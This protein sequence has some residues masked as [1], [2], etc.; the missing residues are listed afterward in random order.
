MADRR[1]VK[2]IVAIAAVILVGAAVL[3]AVTL[4]GGNRTDL[5]KI[6]VRAKPVA[7]V[8]FKD[9]QLGRTPLV[10]QIPR[11]TRELPIE[12]TFTVHKLNG[13]NGA[14]KEEV[15]KQTKTIVPDAPQSVDFDIKA[16]TKQP[17][18]P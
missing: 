11:G 16:A 5:V 3:V 10:I 17:E 15:W 12:A 18:S 1:K 8:R 6:E 4:S 9:K 2:L 7:T 13:M 14:A